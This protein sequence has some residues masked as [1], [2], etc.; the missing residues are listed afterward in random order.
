MPHEVRAP[1]FD[2]LQACRRI[3]LFT[4]GK[5]FDDYESDEMLRSAV[6]RQL[7]IVGEALGRLRRIAPE[8]AE[9]IT[10]WRRI[11]AFRNRLI[12]GY[13]VI[14]NAVVWGVVQ[15]NI[16]L[17]AAEAEALLSEDA[18]TSSPS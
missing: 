8:M 13:D 6:E 5:T 9:G 17:L 16:P 11:L 15:H 10:D 12:H 18:D 7:A 4:Q 1:L 3:T 2:M 14:T